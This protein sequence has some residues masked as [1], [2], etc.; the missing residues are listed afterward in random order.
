[1]PTHAD[2]A[3]WLRCHLRGVLR[4][5]DQGRRIRYVVDRPTG[6]LVAPLRHA[7]LDADEIVLHIP[8]EA[9]DCAHLL[10][11]ARP[12]PESG[13]TDHWLAYHGSPDAPVWCALDV[14]MV[15]LAGHLL[16]EPLDLANPIGKDEST[17]CRRF[18]ADPATLGALCASR[19]VNDPSP[20]LVGLDPDG[21]DVRARTGL[22]RF[23]FDRVAHNADA[24]RAGVELAIESAARSAGESA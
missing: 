23:E 3:R 15:R 6:A 22:V 20:V 8:D 9:D 11:T 2:V 4:A 17:L 19:G 13:A 10:A 16:D 21:F 24:A 12:I 14:E 18:N 5:D 1:M 7:E